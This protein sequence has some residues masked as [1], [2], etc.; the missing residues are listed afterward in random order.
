MIGTAMLA[1]MRLGLWKRGEES[2]RYHVLLCVCLVCSMAR[3]TA[4]EEKTV[5]AQRLALGR[6]GRGLAAPHV[7]TRRLR[8]SERINLI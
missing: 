2:G 4:R 3:T 8:H 7:G 5:W 1:R 6:L